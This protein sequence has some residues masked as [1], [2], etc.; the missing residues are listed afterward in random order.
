MLSEVTLSSPT[1]IMKTPCALVLILSLGSVVMAE[2]TR[3]VP[4]PRVRLDPA[5][6]AAIPEP[7]RSD[8]TV[9]ASNSSTSMLVMDKYVVRSTAIPR[10]GPPPQQLADGKWSPIK[11]GKFFDGKIGGANYEVGMWPWVELVSFSTLSHQDMGKAREGGPRLNVDLL[12][13]NW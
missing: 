5:T 13:L 6:K 8:A 7:V 11:G 1:P 3:V 2:E 4:Q 9:A 12:H 10:L